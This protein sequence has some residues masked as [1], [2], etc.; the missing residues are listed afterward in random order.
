MLP[1]KETLMLE[2]KARL[3]VPRF[4]YWNAKNNCPFQKKY[5]NAMNKELASLSFRS[6]FLKKWKSILKT[7]WLQI[8]LRLKKN[9]QMPVRSRH[10]KKNQRAQHKRI[11]ERES[12]ENRKFQTDV[13][14]DYKAGKF[15]LPVKHLKPIRRTNQ[16]KLLR[17][18]NQRSPMKS[19]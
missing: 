18:W 1:I 9:K 16:S 17:N 14:Q 6:L 19:Q 15:H 13:A 7:C 12:S 2:L 10:Q 8:R 3:V 11:V 4:K 5:W